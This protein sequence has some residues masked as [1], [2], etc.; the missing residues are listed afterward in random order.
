[1]N[2]KTQ[3]YL[4][5]KDVYLHVLEKLLSSTALHHRNAHGECAIHSACMG[6]NTTAIEFL[7]S[8]GNQPNEST[9]KGDT[10]LHYA[11]R[12]AREDIVMLL[13]EKGADP[14]LQSLT[15]QS[16]LDIAAEYK[17]VELEKKLLEAVENR[18]ILLAN[19]AKQRQLSRNKRPL[20]STTSQSITQT[21]SE[22]ESPTSARKLSRSKSEILKLSL[23]NRVMSRAG[24]RADIGAEITPKGKEKDGK[25]SSGS[26]SNS[27]KR[28]FTKLTSSKQSPDSPSIPSLSSSCQSPPLSGRA[29]SAYKMDMLIDDVAEDDQMRRGKLVLWNPDADSFNAFMNVIVTP[30]FMLVFDFGKE[31]RLKRIV[32]RTDCYAFP[33]C[34]EVSEREHCF[35]VVSVKDGKYTFLRFSVSSAHGCE[36]WVRSINLNM[37]LKK[38]CCY[39][40]FPLYYSIVFYS[41]SNE[42]LSYSTRLTVSK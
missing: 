7:L 28:R 26:G 14:T 29:E 20:S 1:M 27:I 24:S 11:V 34:F 6:G 37:D 21:T 22:P 31:S 5:E 17:M 36:E 42:R 38:V 18:K 3:F 13:L 39:S 30:K 8:K 25:E 4:Q 32:K 2:L 33:L 40:Q 41:L 12:S 15:G 23:K 35:D 9:L 10:P 16:P 19:I